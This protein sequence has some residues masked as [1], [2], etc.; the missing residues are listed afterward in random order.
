MLKK[1]MEK[2]ILKI[3]LGIFKLGIPVISSTEFLEMVK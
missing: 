1:N 3:I 2:I